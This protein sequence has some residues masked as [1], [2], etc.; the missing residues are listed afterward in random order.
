MSLFLKVEILAGSPEESV[1]ADL[2]DLAGQLRIMVEADHNGVTMR[3]RPG[4]TS[5]DV[6]AEYRRDCRLAEYPQD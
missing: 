6:L 3:A 5:D 2:A 4:Q 1:A